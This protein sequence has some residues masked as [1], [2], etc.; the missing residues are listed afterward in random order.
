MPRVVGE[1]KRD[2]LERP[3]PPTKSLS[4]HKWF[5]D[6]SRSLFDGAMA[7]GGHFEAYL[8][9]RAERRI[10]EQASRG[11]E[12]QLEVLGFLLGEVNQWD[13]RTYTLIRGTGT[14]TLKSTPSNVRFDHDA[15]PQLFLELDCSGFDYIIVGWYH[16]HPGHT[17][18]LSR[19]DLETQ[20][21]MFDQ[22]YHSALVVDPIN[23][24]IKMFKLYGSGYEEIPFAVTSAVMPPS[25]WCRRVRR[26][27]DSSKL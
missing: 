25:T 12:E 3:P 7:D 5:S 4:P 19:T 17:C 2:M 20:R 24:E 6:E 23:E 8:S 21:T 26:L 16:S 13:G 9:D 15:L 14:T 27:K 11:A 10:M 18:F 1:T 22:A